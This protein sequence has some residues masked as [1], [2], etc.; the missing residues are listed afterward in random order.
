MCCGRG[1]GA[2]RESNPALEIRIFESDVLCLAEMYDGLRNRLP[3][4][5]TLPGSIV[6]TFI[7]AYAVSEGGLFQAAL[8]AALLSAAIL[9]Y[10]IAFRKT[11]YVEIVKAPIH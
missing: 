4:Q 7:L 3:M 9:L 11:P 10:L 5:L 8:T 2:I 1:S 6:L